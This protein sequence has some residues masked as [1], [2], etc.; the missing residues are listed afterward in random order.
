MRLTYKIKKD[1]I[2]LSKYHPKN[3][4]NWYQIQK[5]G[6]LEDIEDKLGIDALVLLSAIVQEKIYIKQ[7]DEIFENDVE[8][9]INCDENGYYI[10]LEVCHFGK[11]YLKDYGKTWALTGD[12]LLCERM[13]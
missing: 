5:L 3:K 13:R 4:G 6:Q 2:Y 1:N 8:F 9:S 11:L 7:D 12:E 10:N